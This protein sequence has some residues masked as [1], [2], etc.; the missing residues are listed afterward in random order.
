MRDI[1]PSL[2][3]FTANRKLDGYLQESENFPHFSLHRAPD[4]TDFTVRIVNAELAIQAKINSSMMAAFK[5]GNF[6]FKARHLCRDGKSAR[7]TQALYNCAVNIK[8]GPILY[9]L[10]VPLAMYERTFLTNGRF[11]TQSTVLLRI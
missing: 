1:N 3:G 4:A 5:L 10:P 9:P 6:L 11:T 8:H 7:P 2:S